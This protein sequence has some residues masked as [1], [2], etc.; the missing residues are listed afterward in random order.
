MQ[1]Q[2][3]HYQD[4]SGLIVNAIGREDFLSGEGAFPFLRAVK[5][6]QPERG[7]FSTHLYT[8]LQNDK[9][10]RIGKEKAQ[11]RKA[12]EVIPL[13]DC[14]SLSGGVNPER[15]VEFWDTLSKLSPDAKV[16]IRYILQNAMA[17]PPKR[18]RT[19]WPTPV[20]CGAT[21]LRADL[22]RHL[23]EEGWSFPR[24]WK[25]IK[26]IKGALR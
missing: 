23:R 8:T 16:A 15:E 6:Y 18:K 25:M 2:T 1:T 19:K 4:H 3:T 11:K 22:Q 10:V 17:E 13:D 12:T 9:R 24:I 21:E 20:T 14:L 7:K 5:T 26:E